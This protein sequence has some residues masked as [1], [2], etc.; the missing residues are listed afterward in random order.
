[1]TKSI[2]ALYREAGTFS[3]SDIFVDHISCDFW[4]F[5]IAGF[6]CSH[7]VVRKFDRS[8]KETPQTSD[9]QVPFYEYYAECCE[10]SETRS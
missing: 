7:Y 3:S 5:F 9:P 2:C 1:M 8:S 6:T 10:T 4:G